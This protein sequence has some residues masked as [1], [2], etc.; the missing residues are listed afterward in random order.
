[1]RPSTDVRPMV[2]TARMLNSG[3]G[4]DARAMGTN[5]TRRCV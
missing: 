5:M 2:A 4:I 1:M 3:I